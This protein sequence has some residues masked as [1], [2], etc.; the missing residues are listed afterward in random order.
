MT[1]AVDSSGE[2][3]R[4]HVALYGGS[5]NPPH[6]GHLVVSSYVLA[7]QP[8]ECIWLMPCFQHAF[9]KTLEPFEKR[10]EM[11]RRMSQGVILRGRA[12]VTDVEAQLGGE[13]RT[14]DTVKHLRARH[15]DTAFDLVLGTDI[16][17]DRHAW[18]GFD[19]LET[20]CRFI[21]LGRR[22]FDAPD[23][24]VAS[25]PLIDVSSTQVRELLKDRNAGQNAAVLATLVPAAVLSYIEEEGLFE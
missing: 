1:Q 22:G 3:E 7:T 6:I 9:A 23:N 5:F 8:V 15:P 10:M 25:P 16:F 2:D 4:R 13:S 20:L 11:A 21:V 24:H 18:K 17:M 12:Y 19:E 14:I